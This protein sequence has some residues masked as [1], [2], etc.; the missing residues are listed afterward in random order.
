[1]AASL[2][3]KKP[4]RVVTKPRSANFTPAERSL[5]TDLVEVYKDTIENKRTDAYTITVGTDYVRV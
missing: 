5:L 2:K 1:M 4:K 3:A